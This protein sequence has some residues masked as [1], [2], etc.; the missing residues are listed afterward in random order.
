MAISRHTRKGLTRTHSRRTGKAGAL[1][2]SVVRVHGMKATGVKNG[3]N[4]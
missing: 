4:K 3:R 1:A 2:H